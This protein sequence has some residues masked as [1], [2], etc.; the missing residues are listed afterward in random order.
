V[1]RLADIQPDPALLAAA[2]A[3]DTAAQA[4]LYRLLAGPAHALARRI[5][6]DAAAA[7]DLLQDSLLRVFQGLGQYRAEAPFGHWVRSIVTRGGLMYLRSPWQR[8]RLAWR[9][10][11]EDEDGPVE[12]SD[13]IAGGE[14]R[15]PGA[16]DIDAQVDLA[17]ALSRLGPVPR[18]V[19]WLH[20]V[21]GLTH[22]EIAA[23]FGR[24]SSF[25]KSQLARAHAALRGWLDGHETPACTQGR[26]N[27]LESPT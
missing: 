13:G 4:Q 22:D 10:R 11:Q 20:D 16:A 18:A 12:D 1:S 21:E 3:G 9:T 19:V 26:S 7:E 14:L 8:A 27:Q 25:S 23:G 17:R 24:T 5:V 6:G 2:T 15:D